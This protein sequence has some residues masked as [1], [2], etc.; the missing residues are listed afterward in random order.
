[1]RAAP[2]GQLGTLARATRIQSHPGTA[3]H[4]TMRSSRQRGRPIPLRWGAVFLRTPPETMNIRE[5]SVRHESE[6][7]KLFKSEDEK[8]QDA[9][10][11]NGKA[12]GSCGGTGTVGNGG[13]GSFTSSKCGS[14]NGSGVS[15]S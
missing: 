6:M 11:K 13:R 9:A 14:C 3:L 1:M 15:R 2:A 8:R 10:R 5:T 12:C 7:I 4:R